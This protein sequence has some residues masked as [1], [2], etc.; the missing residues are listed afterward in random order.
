MIQQISSY[1][2]NY[3]S[4][5]ISQ[6]SFYF[7]KVLHSEILPIIEHLEIR[8]IHKNIIGKPYCNVRN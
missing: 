8:L 2:K 5:L 7:K 1:C 3:G 4:L 6:K